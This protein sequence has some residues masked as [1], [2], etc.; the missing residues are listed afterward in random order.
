M[1]TPGAYYSL[2]QWTIG[3]DGE[4]D[5]TDSVPSA[6]FDDDDDRIKN[7]VVFVI[8]KLFFIKIR[9]VFCFMNRNYKC[10]ELFLKGIIHILKSLLIKEVM[11]IL[12]Y[13]VQI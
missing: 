12:E 6:C 5:S 10:F 2:E 13:Y 1:Q 7:H 8:E 9:R 3:I 11:T 4:I